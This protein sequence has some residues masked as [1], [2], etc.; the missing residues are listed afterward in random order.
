M[1]HLAL[2]VEEE[3]RPFARGHDD[4]LTPLDLDLG[5]VRLHGTAVP[6]VA[7]LTE[8]VSGDGG[9][10]ARLP[11]G[12]VVHMKED[13]KAALVRIQNRVLVFPCRATLS[14]AR[15]D[16]APWSMNV[17]GTHQLAVAEDVDRSIRVHPWSRVV[18]P[19]KRVG[20]QWLPRTFQRIRDVN[21]R[22]GSGPELCVLIR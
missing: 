17:L 7:I 2:L 20:L 13:M 3:L 12:V 21:A 4:R 11:I 18:A 16:E 14:D 22:A 6:L 15:G 19:T 5:A 1:R 9:I 10:H 8:E